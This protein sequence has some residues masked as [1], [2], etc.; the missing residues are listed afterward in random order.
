MA[1]NGWWS[2]A[3]V[4][5]TL[6]LSYSVWTAL[7][8]DIRVGKA[9]IPFN[10]PV[11]ENVPISDRNDPFLAAFTPCPKCDAYSVNHAAKTRDL[12]EHIAT[13]QQCISGTASFRETEHDLDVWCKTPSG[14]FKA[15]LHGLIAC[16]VI[17]L[18]GLTIGW[19][20]AGFQG[21][22]GGQKG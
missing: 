21:R 20:A 8:D 10:S 9:S 15:I 13:A 22:R 1:L 6:I 14:V 17:T 7:S 18:F 12:A 4:I 5:M 2:I 19:I 16:I 3:S 11:N